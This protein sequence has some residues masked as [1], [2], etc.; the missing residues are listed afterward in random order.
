MNK[1]ELIKKLEAQKARSAWSKGVKNYAIDLVNDCE[2]EITL[3]NLLN[4]AKDWNQYSEDGSTLV[5]NADIAEALCTPSE[6]KR[7]DYGRL[8]PNGR[9]NWI[10]CQTRALRQ[11]W[12]LIKRT[13]K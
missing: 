8:P 10:E 3:E 13:M 12:T 5:Y 4:G 9:E 1:T 6:L 2:G 11:A 7:T